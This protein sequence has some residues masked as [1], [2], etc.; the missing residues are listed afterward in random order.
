MTP[1]WATRATAVPYAVFGDP[2]TLNLYTYVENSPINR[3]DADGHQDNNPAGGCVTGTP[4]CTTN[5]SSAAKDAQAQSPVTQDNAGNVICPGSCPGLKTIVD[6]A[7]TIVN[8]KDGA[9]DILNG[10]AEVTVT[11][12]S[13]PIKVSSKGTVSGQLLP[14]AGG[15]I[16]V[17]MPAPNPA[18]GPGGTVSVGEPSGTASA[19]LNIN[20]GSISGV[21]LSVGYT[22]GLVRAPFGLN[23]SAETPVLNRIG[24]ALLNAITPSPSQTPY[25]EREH[26]MSGW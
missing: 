23:A 24:R 21:T 16:D 6:G 5:P 25:P 13:G 18:A 10:A 12:K 9:V 22:T 14:T 2:Q 7:R 17:R 15:T 20:N 11:E 8:P 3:V 1:D 26:F 19:A 4:G